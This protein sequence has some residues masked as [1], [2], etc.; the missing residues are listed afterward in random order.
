VN[1]RTAK[2]AAAGPDGAMLLARHLGEELGRRCAPTQRDLVVRAVHLLCAARGDGHACVDLAEA[3][4]QAGVVAAELPEPAILRRELLLSGVCGDG[5]EDTPLVLDAHD[6][7]WL[8]RNYRA[9]QRIAAFV[10]R[11]LAAPPAF[12][13]DELRAPMQQLFPHLG[14]GEVDAQALAVLAAARARFAVLTGG[15][16]TGKTTTVVRL[17]ALLWQLQPELSAAFCA[18]TGKAAARL[19]D[20]VGS[21]AEAL[22]VAQK[23]AAHTR[24]LTLHRLLE[25]LPLPDAFR[26]NR[27]RPLAYDLVVVDEASMVDIALF[28][29]L[30]QALPAHA[31][32]LVVGDRDQLASVAAG[33]VLGDLCRAAAPEL[34]PG[35]QLWQ[36]WRSIGGAKTGG[37]ARASK[38]TSPLADVTVALRRNWRFAGQPGLGGFAQ[39]LAARMPEDALQVLRAGHA[40]L[41][42]APAATGALDAL[43]PRFLQVVQATAPAAAL[44]ALQA[45]RI[46]CATRHGPHGVTAWNRLVEQALAATG[47]RTEAPFHRGR[48][49]LVLQNDHQNRLYNGDVGIAWPG[50]DGRPLVWFAAPDGGLRWISPLRLPAH[51]TAWAMTVHKAQGSEFDEVLLLMP[52]RD[53]P[54]WQAALVYT[55]V[56]RAR[57]RCTIVA[58]EALLAPALAR[59][60]RRRSGLADL[61]V[62]PVDQGDRD[63][64]P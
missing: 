20:A 16:G 28:D 22:G 8:L 40:D 10:R 59:W 42:W 53:G 52:D 35:E 46:L 5:T 61:L 44:T 12:A 54:L 39:A 25:Y 49:V 15:P 13:P 48:P 55:G 38:G 31:R 27:E 63:R 64:A 33:Q 2:S 19:A 56:T 43:L 30:L 47:V 14:E 6:R 29:A 23:L 26:R 9:E 41:R 45:A 17:L 1:A 21:Q 37:A 50:E 62:E 60:P 58:A 11:A 3:A 36:A 57:Q 32:L 4:A 18:P 34:G 7:L 24:T 51:E